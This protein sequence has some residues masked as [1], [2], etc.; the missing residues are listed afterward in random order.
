[1]LVASTLSRKL[2][3]IIGAAA[4][5]FLGTF[6][7]T[8]IA[9]ARVERRLASIESHDVPRLELGVRLAQAFERIQRDFL[10]PMAARDLSS[11][12][13]APT[14][15]DEYLAELE[16]GAPLLTP[17]ET[18]DLQ[19]AFDAWW[20][21]ASDMARRVVDGETGESVLAEMARLQEAQQQIRVVIRRISSVD[22]RVL[23]ARLA[24]AREAHVNARR[25]NLLTTG[26]SL[27]LILVLALT[28]GRGILRSVR[29][30]TAG[31]ARFG[32]GEFTPPIEVHGDAELASVSR[33]AN[34][35]AINL[36]HLD[37]QREQALRRL[38]EKAAELERMS[39]Y[40]SQFLANT[41]HEL[42]T[43]LNSMLLLS[44]LLA[45]NEG[46]RLSERQVGFARTIHAAG[47]ELLALIDQ[48][49]DL[50]K[51]E[52]G[53]LEVQRGP[54]ALPEIAG[55]V[56]R[57]FA[58]LA[59]EKGLAFRVELGA[60]VPEFIHTDRQRLDQVLTNLLGNAIK[61]TDRGEV[62]L[63]IH[64][65][66]SRVSFRVSDTGVGVPLADQQRI[67]AP[68]EQVEGTASRRHGGTGLGL[69]IA[70]ELTHLLGGE[71]HVRSEPGQGSTFTCVLPV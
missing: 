59:R 70:R 61:F 18:A 1:V 3:A 10:E 30:L 11:L 40:K 38:A 35:M 31:F 68:F 29:E 14:G 43:P 46:G 22:R 53:R 65:D 54:V 25:L 50:A 4:L 66:G 2:L 24:E 16:R 5:G 44:G 17:P 63:R 49:L 64:G 21:R 37:A 26:L 52:A 60:E 33:E 45:E 34:H 36:Q 58:P 55:R 28:L 32:R 8:Q 6:V 39:A 27:T 48:V 41:S 20:R 51:L 57:V 19:A 9:V 13:N 71:L 62:A 67:F 47:K 42:R 56:E 12:R 15:R 7:V 23:A 69:T